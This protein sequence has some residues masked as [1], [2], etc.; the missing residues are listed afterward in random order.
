MSLACFRR[1]THFAVARERLKDSYGAGPLIEP[2]LNGLMSP[3]WWC[4]DGA[5]RGRGD[6]WKLA[7]AYRL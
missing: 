7:E 6:S 3:C 1:G 4:S 2:E 5:S